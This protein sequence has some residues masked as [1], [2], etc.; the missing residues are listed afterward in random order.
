MALEIGIEKGSDSMANVTVTTR[1]GATTTLKA[2]TLDA[3]RGRLRGA[4]CLPG[5]PGYDTARTIWNAMI[6]RRPALVVRAAGAADVIQ[7]VNLAR[8]HGLVLAVR[9][10]GH[11]IAGNAVRD[12]ALLLDLTLMKSV[13]VDPA[14]RIAWA[15]PGVTL[16]EFDKETQAFALATPVGINSTT[17]MA[18]LTLGGGFG[19]ISR[20]YG[21]TVD[22]LLAADVVTADGKLRRC[23]DKE[24]ADLFWAIRGGG[25]NFGVVTSFEYRLHPVGPEVLAGLVVHPFAKAKEILDGYRRL[26]AQ[27]P[28]ELTCWAVMRKAPPLPFLPSEVHGTEILVLAMCYAGDIEQG[29]KAMAA[30]RGL[31]K[32]LA[33]VVGPQPFVGWQTAFDPLLTPGARNYWKSHDFLELSDGFLALLLDAIGKLPTPDCEIFIGH[34][35]AAVNQV[36]ANA[37]A[38]PHRNVHF[39]MNVHTRWN[40]PKQDQTCIAWARAL[41]DKAAPFATGGVYVNFMPEDETQRVETGAYGPNFERL[42]KVK[43]QYDPDNLFRVNQN[44]RPRG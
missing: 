38:Y 24:N 18:G 40:D 35:G 2:E 10:G 14:N 27:A 36:P 4:L 29:K 21:L 44:I 5:E 41:F 30:L 8:E 13:R 43:A 25:G 6:D 17:G 34:L 22:N 1:N 15:E 28:P 32:P 12:G 23:S 20:K 9:G 7:T 33:D 31:G 16:G 11:N 42:S 39:I 19:W 37:T 3:L 26:V